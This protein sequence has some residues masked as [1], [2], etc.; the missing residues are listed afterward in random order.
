M[1]FR[2]AF[3]LVEILVVIGIMAML[4]G[5][6]LPA[7]QKVRTTANRMVSQNNMKQI[8]LA[9]HNRAATEDERLPYIADMSHYGSASSDEDDIFFKLLPFVESNLKPANPADVQDIRQAYP[10]VKCYISPSDPSLTVRRAMQQ[11]MAK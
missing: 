5:L 7:I 1:R 4:I 10:R 11:S 6:L 8:A 3:T 2:R 9:I